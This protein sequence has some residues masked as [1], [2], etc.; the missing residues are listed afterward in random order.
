MQ[1]AEQKKIQE[2]PMLV[3]DTNV[4]IKH[5]NIQDIF[6]EYDVYTTK[7]V[8]SEL[9]D[10][11]SKQKAKLHFGEYKIKK[12]SEKA[13]VWVANFAKKTGDFVSI[14]KADTEVIA[15]TVEEIWNK[16][17]GEHLNSEP[18]KGVSLMK[19]DGKRTMEVV[20]RDASDQGKLFY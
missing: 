5:Q 12:P 14:S 9:R 11:N 4:F 17:L 1:E 6:N 7:S 18:K 8:I 10:P 16:G 19:V 13:I 15:L 3:I 20:T 2:K